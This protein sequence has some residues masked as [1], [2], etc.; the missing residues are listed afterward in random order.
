MTRA[1]DLPDPGP[2]RMSAAEAQAI[3]DAI[4]QVTDEQLAQ[5]K[6]RLATAAK[7]A[8]DART[9]AFAIVEALS[10]A[11]SVLRIIKGL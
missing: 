11:P 1:S 8:S 3:V 9:V 5:V 4:Q 10:I 2:I 6:Q 7:N